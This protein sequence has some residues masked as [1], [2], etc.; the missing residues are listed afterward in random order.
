MPSLDFLLWASRISSKLLGKKERAG[1]TFRVLNTEEKGNLGI[2]ENLN[3]QN[4]Q[5][6]LC[7]KN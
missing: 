5:S 2:A 6:I 3:S 4:A 1:S 7:L